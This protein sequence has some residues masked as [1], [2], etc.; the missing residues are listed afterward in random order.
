VIVI[1]PQRL[2]ALEETGNNPVRIGSSALVMPI[3]LFRYLQVHLIT[4][5]F[6]STWRFSLPMLVAVSYFQK[7]DPELLE[8]RMKFREKNTTALN[9]SF[10]RPFIFHG[11]LSF[12]KDLNL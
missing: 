11:A 4:C 8:L 6:G 7:A 2:N 9:S 12:V 3:I 10:S 5:M 1:E